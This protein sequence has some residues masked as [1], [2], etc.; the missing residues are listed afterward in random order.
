MPRKVGKN[1]C[2]QII[3]KAKEF[4]ASLAGITNVEALKESPSHFIY[5]KLDTYKGVGSKESGKIKPGEIVWP[6]HSK[7]AIVIAVEHPEDK[8]ELDWW[9]DGY[10]GGTSGN[11]ILMSISDRL[12]EWLDEKKR[13]KANTLPYHIEHGGIFLK[14]IAVLSGLGCLGKNNM[15]VTPEFGPRVRLRV[16]LTEEI[17][18][19]TNPIDFDPC[20][21]CS[22]PCKEVCPQEAFQNKIYLKEKF[23]LDKLP[24]RTGVYDRHLCNVQMELDI[25]HCDKVNI[26]GQDGSGKM[27][28]F[29][30]RCEFTCPIGY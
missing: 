11:E 24:A 18:S 26:K 15:L 27:V 5:D 4:G 3:E 20:K 6:E 8:P 28:K 17:L 30:R 21:E 22:M 25:D 9:K 12:S 29:C 23:G 2:G 14:D 7:S 16:M 10:P 19:P 1:I 13:I